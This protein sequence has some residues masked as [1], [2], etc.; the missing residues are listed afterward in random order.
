MALFVSLEA[1]SVFTHGIYP[2]VKTLQVIANDDFQRLPVID[3]TGN[4][5]LQ[6]SFD[7]LADEQPWIDYTL[8]HCNAKWE[9]DDLD[10]M[11]YLNY[12]YLPVHCEEVRPSFNTFM[13]YYH[14]EV[15]FPT[16]EIRPA[17]SGN[18]A[19]IFH[20]QDHP[21]SIVAVA[22]F[23]VS[24]QIA[25]VS[26]TSSGNTDIG[27]QSQ[28]QQVTME[29]AWSENK[30]PYLNPADDLH[31]L[32]RQNGRRD[33]Q[34]WIEQPS[35]MSK[36]KAIYEHQKELI[37][38]AGNHWRRF[39]FTDE[40]YPGLGVD[41]VRYHSP[42]YF[43]YLRPDRARNLDNYRYDQDQHGRFKVHALH[44][45]D[46]DTE[47]EYFMAMF[48]LDAP[49]RLDKEGI[50]LFGEFTCQS[51]DESTRMEYD[52][53]KGRYY[54]E[55]LLKE[56]AYNYQYLVPTPNGSLST[57][58]VEGNHF[59]TPNEY[60]VFVYYRPFGSRSDRLLGTATIK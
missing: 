2:Q 54:K 19:M 49:A 27:F 22:C 32:V 30:L 45:D 28:H 15:K 23:M 39:E 40:R 33:N 56:G 16:E 3:L 5:T 10:E 21:D 17:I 41:R 6:V 46:M 13:Q 53:E 1:Q 8:V 48:E 42:I 44:V 55:V 4:T 57:S 7:W 52:W 58:F 29:I 38:E 37:F 20:L 59:E 24:E 25:F 18:Y 50:Y 36:S 43:A 11:D 26:G 51:L 9:R 34:R 47:A 31:V 14:F 60:Q 12:S 35:R